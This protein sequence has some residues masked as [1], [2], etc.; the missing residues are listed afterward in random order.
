MAITTI[1]NEYEEIM[2]IYRHV[3]KNRNHLYKAKNTG[4]ARKK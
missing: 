2:G 4:D 3:Q 1:Y